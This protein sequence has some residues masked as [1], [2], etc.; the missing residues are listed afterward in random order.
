MTKNRLNSILELA[1]YEAE[2]ERHVRYNLISSIMSYAASKNDVELETAC[3][4]TLNSIK[5]ESLE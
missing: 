3:A 4:E 2:D 1:R 5:S